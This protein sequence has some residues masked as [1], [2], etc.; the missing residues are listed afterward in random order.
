[1]SEVTKDSGDASSNFENQNFDPFSPPTATET[2]TFGIIKSFLLKHTLIKG[3]DVISLKDAQASDIPNGSK[4]LIQSQNPFK[5]EVLTVV[6][7][8]SDESFVILNP[9]SNNYSHP[10]TTVDLVFVPDQKFSESSSCEVIFDYVDL[11]DIAVGHNKTYVFNFSSIESFDQFEFLNYGDHEV[12]KSFP[13]ITLKTSA[14]GADNPSAANNT[15]FYKTYNKYGIVRLSNNC[16]DCANLNF[17]IFSSDDD[18]KYFNDVKKYL[19]NC[20]K[21]T[22]TKDVLDVR[23]LHCSG[24][25]HYTYLV[26]YCCDLSKDISSDYCTITWKAKCIDPSTSQIDLSTPKLACKTYNT[27]FDAWVYDSS[28]EKLIYNRKVHLC[29]NGCTSYDIH[30]TLFIEPSPP[31]QA[32]WENCAC[33]APTPTITNTHSA[34]KTPQSLESLHS[35]DLIS[36]IHLAGD[37]P[38]FFNNSSLCGVSEV[39][40]KPNSDDLDSRVFYKET[41]NGYFYEEFSTIVNDNSNGTSVNGNKILLRSE[42]EQEKNSIGKGLKNQNY[43]IFS[44]LYSGDLRS[45][46][47][48]PN[49]YLSIV[50]YN[51]PPPTPTIS[52][53]NNLIKDKSLF[54]KVYD[55]GFKENINDL[56]PL[57]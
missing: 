7:H 30:P 31:T 20:G 25:N 17:E 50:D 18:I 21:S 10:N 22:F 13:T 5:S 14:S 39:T 19:L 1:M 3:R 33:N 24:G 27:V 48:T 12:T 32:Q 56:N 57:S 49:N 44:I 52:S 16:D 26:T 42:T 4:L 35:S 51:N 11:Y 23:V 29:G 6:A 46:N 53:N 55:K 41:K 43:L 38:H 36:N 9:I 8:I 45:S 15:F 2:I 54:N 37:A 40:V 47:H 34:T 28:A